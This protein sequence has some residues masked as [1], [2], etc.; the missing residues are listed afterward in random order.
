LPLWNFGSKNNSF[1]N[2]QREVHMLTWMPQAEVAKGENQVPTR[3]LRGASLT[4]FE[5]NKKKK[6]EE[7]ITFYVP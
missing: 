7:K 2:I 1:L 3:I 6:I 5:K 4:N